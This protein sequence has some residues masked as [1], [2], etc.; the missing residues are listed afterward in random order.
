MSSNPPLSKRTF[1]SPFPQGR[2]GEGRKRVDRLRF[3]SDR[4]EVSPKDDGVSSP[5]TPLPTEDETR[6]G[7]PRVVIKVPPNRRSRRTGLIFG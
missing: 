1:R 6:R 2:E 5:S 3:G 7:R 4:Y